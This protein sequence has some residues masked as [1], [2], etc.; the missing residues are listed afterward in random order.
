MKQNQT[1]V[2]TPV[3][4]KAFAQRW[5]E[6]YENVKVP[7]DAAFTIDESGNC[8][9]SFDEDVVPKAKP[10]SVPAPA[11]GV[12]E[13]SP[14]P[15]AISG[16]EALLAAA[17][18]DV[19][20]LSTRNIAGTENGNLGCAAAVTAILHD[21]LHLDIATTLSTDVLYD[22]LK[23]ARWKEV[24][25]DTPG[26]VI[27]SPTCSS[28]HG[29][30]GIIGENGL[31]YSNSSADGTW[32]Q[33]FKVDQWRKYYARC[34][35]HAFVPPTADV[36]PLPERASESAGDPGSPYSLHCEAT[37]FGYSD[38]GDKGNGAWG[39][40]NNNKTAIGV[41][42]P[43]PI[44]RDSLGGTSS[45]HVMG[46]TVSLICG[47]RTL[48]K[49]QIRDLGPGVTVDGQHGLLIGKD[50]V[51]HALDMTYGL[52]EALGVKYPGSYRVTWWLEDPNGKAIE[53]KGLDAPRKIV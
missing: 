33:N 43:I 25:T 10:V 17:L 41:S 24:S 8:T 26:A 48:R 6:E 27:V 14:G 5:L 28:M 1:F 18:A 29:H 3:E 30:T 39:D 42:V 13:P 45:S 47:S 12:V 19:G 35:S 36:P 46:H 23:T 7:S 51:L 40:N 9:V 32:Q 16:N 44:I 53:L 4:L 38:P 21:Q 31:I 20:K 15:V 49:L 22:E 52:C 2:V 50:G 11:S 34:G 37:T